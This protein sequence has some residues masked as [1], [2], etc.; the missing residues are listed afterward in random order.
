MS[1]APAIE[2][3]DL[4]KSY[5][6]GWLK[7]SSFDALKGI[8]I[9]VN[10]GEIFGLL[11]PNG[12]GKTTFV[13]VLLG[14]IRKSGG[15]ARVL[16]QTAGTRDSRKAVGYLPENLRLQR[17]LTALT[18]LDL[19]GS[20]SNL[21]KATIQRRGQEL[22]KLVGLE[23]R[24]KESIKRFS[25]G[26][27]QRL[28]LAQAMLHEPQL[29]ILDEPTDGL[30]P[31]ARADVRSILTRLKNEHGTTIFLNSHIL[32]E[33]EL[34]CDRVAILDQGILKYC[35]T[36][37][38]AGDFAR[39]GSEPITAESSTAES[40]FTYAF[41]FAS[42]EATIRRAISKQIV[43]E[44]LADVNGV[45]R[46]VLRMK[47]QREVDQCVDK[48]RSNGVSIIGFSKSRASLEDAFLEILGHEQKT[49]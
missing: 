26:M 29:L 6:N 1:K 7:R 28:G 43:G 47:D 40:F 23:D 2:V 20:L 15:S 44:I 21:P 34:V 39:K 45:T 17:H 31:R 16:G 30:D 41:E 14:V 13:K 4:R 46:A 33:V 37:A 12:A 9:S 48:L 10:Q 11:G 27:L 38:Q 5:R 36:V 3:E 18:A 8:S 25:K 22:L 49:K 35:G 42:D 19:Y 32:Q 24:T